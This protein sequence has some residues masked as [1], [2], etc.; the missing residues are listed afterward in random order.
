EYI[1][2]NSRN[3]QQW[4]TNAIE[5]I[6]QQLQIELPGLR[7]FSETSLKKM[8]TFYEAWSDIFSNRP[9]AT[10]DLTPFDLDSFLKV[11]FTHHYEIILKTKSLDERLFY[12]RKCSTE[13]WSVEKLKY[14]RKSKKRHHYLIISLFVYVFNEVE[15][16]CIASLLR[17]CFK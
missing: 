17:G 2:R 7:G 1:S 10:D 6:S 8:R 12:I 15:T 5:V 14:N 13:F 11:G 9:L 4:G 3:G 16:Q